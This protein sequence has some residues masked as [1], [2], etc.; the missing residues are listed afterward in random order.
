[1]WPRMWLL[2][3]VRLWTTIR[4]TD[5]QRAEA[6]LPQQ[7]LLLPLLH[8]LTGHPVLGTLQTCLRQSARVPI[9]RN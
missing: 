5:R 7:R 1:M 6:S 3:V 2:A 8:N 4:S 9:T